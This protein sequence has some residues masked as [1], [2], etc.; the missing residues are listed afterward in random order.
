MHQAAMDSGLPLDTVRAYFAQF[1]ECGAEVDYDGNITGWILSLNP[2]A[3]R[4]DFNGH[5]LYAWCALDTLFLPAL[6]GQP[7]EVGSICPIT[8]AP[9]QLHVTPAGVSAI[10]PANTVLSV[11]VPGISAVC[12]ACQNGEVAKGVC[13]AMR[14][15]ATH[16]AAQWH[17]R[18]L[19]VAILTLEEAWQLAYAVWIEPMTKM[20]ADG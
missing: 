9:I 16:E 3:Y 12:E 17:A 5:P 11:V 10:Q 8:G 20:M 14:F 4:L 13:D 15:F 18:H 6:I 19:D 7:T 1:Q 2:T